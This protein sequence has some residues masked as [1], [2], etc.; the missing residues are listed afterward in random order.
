M[1]RS[2]RKHPIIGWTC[3]ESEKA[4]KRFARKSW[5]A[6]LRSHDQRELPPLLREVS[7]AF[8]FAKDGKQYYNTP[9][10]RRK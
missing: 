6:A 2:R 3:A 8:M 5:R 1:S 4:D 9:E 10:A 7:E